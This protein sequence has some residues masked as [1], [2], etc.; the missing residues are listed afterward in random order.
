MRGHSRSRKASPSASY[1]RGS[2]LRTFISVVEALGSLSLAASASEQARLPGR[3]WP[4]HGDVVRVVGARELHAAGICLERR[5][6]RDLNLAPEGLEC[7]SEGAERHEP[8]PEG[9]VHVPAG[10]DERR[11]VRRRLV[12]NGLVGVRESRR[13]VED[14]LGERA[15]V[16]GAQLAARHDVTLAICVAHWR[17][18]GMHV[19]VVSETP[20]A[21][22]RAPRVQTDRFE[23]LPCCLGICGG[24][25]PVHIARCVQNYHIFLSWLEV[26]SALLWRPRAVRARQS[27]DAAGHDEI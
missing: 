17:A 16:F 9:R 8:R 6:H 15:R 22:I 14:V 2:V 13:H 7:R 12:C 10:G 23:L 11:T 3:V 24:V 25:A 19:L 21:R 27:M 20:T 5:G 1:S 18:H 4:L 26:R